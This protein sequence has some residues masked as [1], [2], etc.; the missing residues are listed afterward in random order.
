MGPFKRK[1]SPHYWMKFQLNGVKVYEST[2][3]TNK[4]LAEQILLNKR[5]EILTGMVPEKSGAKSISFIELADRYIEFI[6]GRLRSAENQEYIIKKMA[7]RFKNKPLNEFVLSDLE[8]IQ[9][10]ILNKG[11]SVRSANHYPRV[12]KT[13][14]NKALDWE[15]V[16]ESV[17]KK[18][19]RCKK[20]K[21][22]NNRLR[23][24]ADQ[25]EAYRLIE[26]CEP[27]YL[28]PIVITALNTGMRL[29]E[30]LKLTWDR[31]DLKN[32]F[33]LLDNQTKNKERR[34]IPINRTLYK[35][36]SSLIRNITSDYVFYN[37]K[38][39]KSFDRI[40]RSWHTALNK[41]KITDFKFHD[42]RHTFASWLVMKGADLASV[43][44][45]LGHKS[46]LM[47]MRYAHLAPGHT[48]KAVAVLDE[49][50]KIVAVENE[51][52]Y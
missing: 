9:N 13:M 40:D 3:T 10:D 5:T 37:P 11:L 1:G 2:K 31:V 41:A 7:L 20:I 16:D 12:L 39:L 50:C 32:G 33:I 30:I 4:K 29:K 45:L 48:R 35:V 24:L 6:K 19:G 22:E 21:G 42:L 25:E 28:R 36:L 44:K 34:E 47:T 46:I 52:K 43:Q 51:G 27:V 18:I 14:F 17:A 38:T 8:K 49:R 15:L 26:A 23:Y